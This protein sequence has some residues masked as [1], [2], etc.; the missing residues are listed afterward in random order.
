MTRFEIIPFVFELAKIHKGWCD[1]DGKFCMRY[2]EY[3]KYVNMY[4]ELDENMKMQLVDRVRNKK[5]RS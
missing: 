4:D 5:K 1:K 2:E 3:P